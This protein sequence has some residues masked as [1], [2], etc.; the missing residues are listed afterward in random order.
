MHIAAT[1]LYQSRSSKLHM[2]VMSG[3]CARDR[4][5]TGRELVCC[6]LVGMQ[7]AAFQCDP[8]CRPSAFQADMQLS[9]QLVQQPPVL[10]KNSLAVR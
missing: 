4:C 9:L 1:D 3:T 5:S 7:V 6:T 2:D 8:D 10:L